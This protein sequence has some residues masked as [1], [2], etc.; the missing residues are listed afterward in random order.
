MLREGNL[1]KKPK[2]DIKDVK[3]QKEEVDYVKYMTI[4]E[5]EHLIKTKEML[6]S[7]GIMFHE[8]MKRRN[9]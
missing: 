2:I 8:L 1:M 6:E 9:K 4:S 7:H 3:V 5:I